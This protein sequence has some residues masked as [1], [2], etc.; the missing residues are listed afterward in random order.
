MFNMARKF[1]P[2]HIQNESVSN[3]TLRSYGEREKKNE[4]GVIVT[5]D[6]QEVWKKA[7]GLQCL[8]NDPPLSTICAAIGEQL[9]RLLA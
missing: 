5:L 3:V 8:P 4:N 1:S 9:S 2:G 6:G 7:Q